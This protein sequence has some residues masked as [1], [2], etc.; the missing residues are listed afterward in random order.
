MGR[1]A[2][3]QGDTVVAIDLHLVMVPTAAGPIPMPL[4]HPFAGTI[5]GGLSSDVR[6]MGMPAATVNSTATNAPAHLPM[7]PGTAFQRPPSNRGTVVTGSV[8]VRINGRAAARHGDVATTCNDPVD[9]PAGA[10]VAAG[11]VLVGE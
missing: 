3:K 7:P 2:A 5:D 8:T 11:T 10:I 9:L 6:I 4:P 1:P